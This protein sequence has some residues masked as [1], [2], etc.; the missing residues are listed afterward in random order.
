MKIKILEFKAHQG[1]ECKVQNHNYRKGKWKV[2]PNFELC[3]ILPQHKCWGFQR[4]N[5]YASSH[6]VPERFIWHKEYKKEIRNG[7]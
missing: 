6:I 3:D 2:N 7:N 4:T 1:N 5:V